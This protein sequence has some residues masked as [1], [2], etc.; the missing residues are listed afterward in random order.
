[1][2]L[3]EAHI[4]FGYLVG[5]R[6]GLPNGSSV[7]V[8]VTGPNARDLYAVVEGRARVVGVVADPAC[9]VTT[10]FLTFMLLCCGRIDPDGPIGDGRVTLGGDVALAGQVARNLRFTI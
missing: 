3:D 1:M 9:T 2:S 8:S 6:A 7:Q 4:A 10:D 5:K